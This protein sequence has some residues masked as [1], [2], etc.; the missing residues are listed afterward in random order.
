[1]HLAF[2]AYVV[3]YITCNCQYADRRTMGNRRHLYNHSLR[4]VCKKAETNNA[5]G[6]TYGECSLH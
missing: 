2:S 1:M 4:T 6:D 3:G 5:A